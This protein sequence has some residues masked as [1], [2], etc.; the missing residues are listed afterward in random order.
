MAHFAPQSLDAEIVG[1]VGNERNVG[2]NQPAEPAIYFSNKQFA[3]RTMNIVVRTA[4][5][6]PWIWSIPFAGRLING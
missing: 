3:A 5:V 1:V 6:T 4:G 2:L